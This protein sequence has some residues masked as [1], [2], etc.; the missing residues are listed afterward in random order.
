M[1][2]LLL[3]VSPES[4]FTYE[5]NDGKYELI[6]IQGACDYP[7][8]RRNFRACVSTYFTQLKNEYGFENL[9][10]FNI[11]TA[12][13]DESVKKIFFRTV[14]EFTTISETDMNVLAEKVYSRLKKDKSLRIDEF[15]A[16]IGLF[17]YRGSDR[18]IQR[19]QFS[20]L[21][22]TVGFESI[23]SYLS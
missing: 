4:I 15:G 7:F 17:C 23:G 18:A 6:H 1:V 22:Y 3:I 13:P 16:N 5:E 19:Q 12:F 9:A 2:N 20:L 8:D 21:A 10:S 14:E 11:T